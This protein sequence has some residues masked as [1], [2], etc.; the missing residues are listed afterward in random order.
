MV[1]FHLKR[2]SV[3]K[4]WQIGKKAAK[5]A[6]RPNG[7]GHVLSQGIPIVNVFRDLLKIADNTREV[8]YMLF[9]KNVL[10]DG[11]KIKSHK[12][13]VGLFDVISLPDYDINYRMIL[14]DK[15]KIDVTEIDKKE[16]GIKLKT[17]VKKTVI[18]GGKIQLNFNDGSNIISDVK[19]A[20]GDSVLF[21]IGTKNIKEVL[22]V[23]EGA[24]V[25]LLEGQ[26]AG[27]Q[28]TIEKVAENTSVFVK[29]DDKSYETSKDK[30][31]VLGKTKS[32]IKTA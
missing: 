17:V 4:T 19:C 15:N 18:A 31:F 22:P 27:K 14:T 26:Y 7:S 24:P 21:E 16:V 30:L 28:G 5:F 9:N 29:L 8:R 11:R 12:F 25:V 23:A 1:K 2:L 32:A 13:L 3:P 6:V 20:V 10:V